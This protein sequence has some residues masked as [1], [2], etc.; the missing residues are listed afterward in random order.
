MDHGA[1]TIG[2]SLCRNFRQVDFLATRLDDL[3][4]F[5]RGF[6]IRIHVRA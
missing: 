1:A 3:E 5:Q 6:R 4:Q 2:L